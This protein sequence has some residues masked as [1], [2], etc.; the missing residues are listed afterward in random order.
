MFCFR[1]PLLRL[2]LKRLDR[3][4]G[5][6]DNGNLL[7]VGQCELLHR[8][9]IAVKQFQHGIERRDVRQSSGFALTRAGT[10]SKQYIT[11]A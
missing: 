4:A 1:E 10:F 2:S 11:W 7:E 9:A 8:R 6:R 3:H 5:Q